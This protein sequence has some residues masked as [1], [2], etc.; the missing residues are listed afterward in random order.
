M[1]LLYATT[2]DAKLFFMRRRLEGL[3]IELTSLRDVS[4]VPEVDETGGDPLE[5]AKIKA[6]AYFSALKTPLFSC[7]SALRLDGVPEALQPGV[8][9]RIIN[10][11]RM[12]DAEMLEHYSGIAS[13][14]GGKV[15][16]R[17]KNAICL[18]LSENE[19]YT[20]DGD[21]ISGEKFIIADKPHQRL[22][23]GF[24][25]DSLS[26]HIETGKYYHDMN[27]AD[28]LVDNPKDGFRNFFIRT[29]KLPH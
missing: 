6:T 20:Y 1:T 23:P 18:I 8:H 29:L 2:N 15:T 10:G 13:Q 12:N 22:V 3:E 27:E 14:M 5:N 21:D 28:K 26:I 11:R 16:A 9:V 4:A 7:D 17:Y 19:I 25:L 24:P